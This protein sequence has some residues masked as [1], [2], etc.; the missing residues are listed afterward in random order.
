[1]NKKDCWAQLQ[2]EKLRI[3]YKKGLTKWFGFGVEV[4]GAGGVFGCRA[5]LCSVN[6]VNAQYHIILPIENR[7]SDMHFLTWILELRQKGL[8]YCRENPR[9]HGVWVSLNMTYQVL[10][11]TIHTQYSQTSY[12]TPLPAQVHTYTSE[13][14]ILSS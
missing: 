3:L 5:S 6:F 13:K 11:I 2:K 12:F 8:W 1:M 10:F 7:R 9:F 4:L 14:I